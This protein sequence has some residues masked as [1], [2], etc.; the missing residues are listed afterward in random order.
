MAAVLLLVVAVALA[1][2]AARLRPARAL[3]VVVGAVLLIPATI[4]VPNPISPD[5]TVTRLV[6]VGFAAGLLWRT[7]THRLPASIWRPG[8]VHA[9][10]AIYVVVTLVAGVGL[11]V[12]AVA[13][14]TALSGWLDVVDQMVV[15]VAGIAAFRAINDDRYA[16]KVLAIGL[17]AITAVGFFEH[18]TGRSWAQLWYRG[19]RSQEGS[20]DARSLVKRS[21]DVRVRGAAQFALEYA[22]LCVMLAPALIAAA[23]LSWRRRWL[24]VPAAAAVVVAIIWSVTRSAVPA[25][26]GGVLLLALFAR[27]KRFFTVLGIGATVTA[28]AVLV[29]P[30]LTGSLSESV[31]PGSVAVRSQRLP[32]LFQ[33]AQQHKVTGL[34]FGGLQASGL[35][36]TDFGWLRIYG[37]VGTVGLVALV[38]LFVTVMVYVGRGLL[39]LDP[40]I[41]ATSGVALTALVLACIAGFVYD[42]FTIMTTGRVIWL[43]AALGLV[44]GERIHLRFPAAA[45]QWR[46]RLQPAALAGAGGL[47]IGSLVYVAWPRTTVIEARF[48]LL[49]ASVEV[50]NYDAVDSGKVL[51]S[52]V[53]DSVS[54]ARTSTFA[55][56]CRSTEAA[57]GEG[58]LRITGPS[59]AAV[60]AGMAQV[61]SHETGLVSSFVVVAQTIPRRG[62]PAPVAD[63]PLGLALF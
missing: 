9:L 10:A 57:A 52:T 30:G 11:A 49:P 15:L 63:A 60:K 4:S 8:P 44:S 21:G 32:L 62:V 23:L 54:R 50:G 7:A 24:L 43:V 22:W 20:L 28:C 41:R 33:L 40:C 46:D 56:Q 12:N 2:S 17:L 6:I 36:T 53:C 37:E 47:I 38:V 34:G 16:L 35:P 1:V 55:A 5:F 45:G 14:L 42:T 13:P 25:L 26:A 27:D 18:V 58:V 59:T 19:I 61:V 3:I 29:Q 31:D 48:E 51:L 39:A